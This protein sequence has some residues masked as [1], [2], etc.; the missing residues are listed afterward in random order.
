MK[1]ISIPA[2]D[3]VIIL[4]Y[5]LIIIIIGILSAQ[6][7]RISSEGF[8]LAGR[9]LNWA[10]IGAALFAANISTIH[11]VGLAA[12]GFKDGIVWGNFEWMATFLLII[13][14]LFFAP[15]YFKNKVSTLPQFLEKRYGPNARSFF[16]FIVIITALF[17]HIGV[18]LYAGAV[19]LKTFF[20]IDI[21]VSI[22][23]ISFITTLYSILGG[24]R[25]IVVIESFQSLILIGGA[26]LLT[27]LSFSLLPDKGI[28]SMAELRAVLRPNQLDILQTGN[29]SILPWYAILLGYP[30]LG[31]YYWCADQTIVQKVL[32]AKTMADAQNGPLFAGFLKI[33]PVFIMV[34]P[35]ILAYA[36]FSDKIADPNDTLMV[37]ISNV[38]PSGLMGLMTAALLA[39]LMS[40]I[41]AAL[42]SVGTLVSLDIVK[43]IRPSTPDKIVLRA[44]R[45]TSL[46]VIILAISWSP[47]IGRFESIFD[48]ISIV[49]SMLSPPVASVFVMGILSRRGNDRVALST[50]IFGLAAGAMVFCLDFDPISGSKLITDGLGIPFL[51]QAWWLFVFCIAFYLISSFYSKPRPLEEIQNLIFT[52][53]HFQGFRSRINSIKDPR[54]WTGIL[55]II[56]ILL[57]VYFG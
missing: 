5:L 28:H 33:L 46:V 16:A 39:A 30:V 48:A 14:A 36:L 54:I 3:L 52:K 9:S 19:V 50:M 21:M 12:N 45:I 20:G 56:M 10:M 8:F 41:S 55:L 53:E 51:M 49:L 18:S 1:D 7:K 23:V 26:A 25:A 17:S 2:F 11:M 35:G 6:R 38:L 31:I 24:L 42:N 4:A 27:I 13:L 34:F 22:L 44:G 32:G 37:L 47:W 57:Y 29:T 43:R 15:F 40:T